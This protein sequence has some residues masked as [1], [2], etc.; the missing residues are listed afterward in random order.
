MAAVP[1]LGGPEVQSVAFG[2]AVLESRIR[3]STFCRAADSCWRQGSRFR[4][5]LGPPT[6]E[7]TDTAG[8]DFEGIFER[9][10]SGD[11]FRILHFLPVVGRSQPNRNG[12][13]RTR[14]GG[15]LMRLRER[16]AV[17]ITSLRSFPARHF[18]VPTPTFQAIHTVLRDAHEDVLDPSLVPHRHLGMNHHGALQ[19][20]HFL[21]LL[22]RGRHRCSHLTHFSNM[23]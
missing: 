10:W 14:E 6:Y 3:S 15:E 21:G 18:A 23:M 16:G 2:D 9:Y 17:P 13:R 20:G 19:D 1:R 22:L 4:V 5:D 8:R 11:I 7:A 12:L